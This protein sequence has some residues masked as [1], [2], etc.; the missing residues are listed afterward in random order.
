MYRSVII[1]LLVTEVFSLLREDIDKEWN[2]FKLKYNRT[3][4]SD[5]EE[6]YRYSVFTES[7]QAVHLHNMAASKGRYSFWLNI[8][9]FADMTDE[10]YED[11]MTG[12]AVDISNKTSEISEVIQTKSSY[13]VTSL[14][15]EV[16]WR[17][18]KCVTSVK[19]QGACGSCYAFSTTGSLESHHCLKSGAL[20]SLSEQ[21][22][23]DCTDN[24]KY[25]NKGCKGG[26]M[27]HAFQYIIDN[28]GI[29][30]EKSY[31]YS[32]EVG[33]CMFEKQAVG[34]TVQSYRD[35]LP[36]GDEYE[37]KKAVGSVGPVSVGVDA[38]GLLFRLYSYGVYDNFMCSSKKLNHGML[39]VGYGT[40]GDGIE[41][42]LLKNSWS[43]FWGLDGY[44]KMIRNK[45]NRCGIASLASYPIV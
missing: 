15:T 8:N 43:T 35:V 27:D 23:I 36:R 29:D 40:T 21:N 41:Y 31:P 13:N 45:G 37:L 34:A 38:R 24:K 25:H 30:T 22:I 28:G 33:R 4:L 20:V 1:L 44:M 9:H 18:E 14:P 7:I 2:I 11:K 26:L 3:F 32:E 5:V 12:L 6:N 19:N 10:E 17:N 39:I 16:D 42:W